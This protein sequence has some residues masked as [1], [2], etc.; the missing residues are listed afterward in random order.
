MKFDI[1]T[2]FPEF[3]DSP[4]KQSIIGRAS[5]QGLISIETQDIRS[6]TPAATNDK[7]KRTDGSPYGGGPGMVMKVEPVVRA[8]EMMKA[9]TAVGG[10]CG[11][12][13]QPKV[14]L[15]TPQGAPL[16][17]GMAGKLARE[18]HLVVVCGR[19][20]GF[21]ERIRAFVDMEVSIG[22]YILTGGESAALVL[23][24]TVARLVPGVIKED[25]AGSDSFSDGLLEYPQYT[26]PEE[27]RGMRVPDVLLSGDHAK[28]KKWRKDKQL[29]RTA[30][31]RPELL[32]GLQDKDK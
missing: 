18:E 32:K 7:Y 16:T 15:L 24:E 21:D 20:E 22:D 11:G 10:C 8:V 6:F 3:F 29:E 31:R 9:Q 12:A 5:E 28:I 4:L 25:S 23:I 1:L 2:L 19:Y 27:F 30:K 14:I 17:Q 13:T 26:R